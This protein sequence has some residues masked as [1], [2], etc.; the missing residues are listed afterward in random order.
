ME[1]AFKYGITTKNGGKR[2]WQQTKDML[3]NPIYAGFVKTKLTE[4]MKKGRHQAL[5]G[6]DIEIVHQQFRELLRSLKPLE[7]V[8]KLFRTVLLRTWQEAELT[9][10]TVH[11]R[12]RLPKKTKRLSLLRLTL[13]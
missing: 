10:W 8:S 13:N 2:S 9:N 5:I 4:K 7:G 3:I 12:T 6:E 1:L 11:N